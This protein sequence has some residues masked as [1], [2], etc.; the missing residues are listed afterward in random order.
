MGNDDFNSVLV[1]KTG[2]ENISATYRVEWTYNVIHGYTWDIKQVANRQMIVIRY[3][4]EL[5]NS[6]TFDKDTAGK[7]IKTR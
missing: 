6:A 7:L 3:A 5:A 1:S 2:G 4:Y